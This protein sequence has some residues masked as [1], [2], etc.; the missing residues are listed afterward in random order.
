[1]HNKGITIF[2]RPGGLH[3]EARRRWGVGG[4]DLRHDRITAPWLLEGPIDGE[5]F[6][7]FVEKVLLPTPRPSGI[8]VMNNLASHRP[9]IK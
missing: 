9:K 4:G 1:V 7:T 6:V 8:V 3:S 2:E 5:N